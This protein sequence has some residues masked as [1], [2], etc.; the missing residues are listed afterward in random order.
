MSYAGPMGFFKRVH[1]ATCFSNLDLKA[2]FHNV[3]IEKAS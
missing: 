3:P 1:G 2:G